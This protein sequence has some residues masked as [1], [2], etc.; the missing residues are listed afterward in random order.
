MTTSRFPSFRRTAS[1]AVA[2]LLAAALAGCET[3]PSKASDASAAASQASAESVKAEAPSA[4]RFGDGTYGFM[5]SKVPVVKGAKPISMTTLDAF[6]GEGVYYF[7]DREESNFRIGEKTG[8]NSYTVKE[9]YPEGQ[10][11]HGFAWGTNVESIVRSGVSVSADFPRTLTTEADGSVKLYSDSSATPVTLRVK[12]YAFDVSGQHVFH[13]LRTR[14]NYPTQTAGTTNAV[15]PKG[16]VAYMPQI[17]AVQD[18]YV[19]LKPNAFTGAGSVEGFARNFSGSIPYCLS[20]LPREGFK[21]YG[22]TFDGAQSGAAAN[23]KTTYKY[24]TKTRYVKNKKGKKVKQTYKVKVPVTTTASSA[25]PGNTGKVSLLPVKTGTVFC[26]STS[27][28][29]VANGNYTIRTV[30]G[31]KGL[32]V[33]F[34]VDVKAPDTGI[35]ELSRNALS[36]ALVEMKRGKTTSVVPG[37]YL[38]ANLPITDFQYRFNAT[39]A[40]AV[41][42]ALSETAA[43]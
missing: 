26:Q 40:K 36:I 32:A 2:V 13:Y 1:A 41:R 28:T 35:F 37:Y 15:F 29:P 42:Q 9:T 16:S 4:D 17:S 24:V 34:P 8:D 19:V 12:L 22:I 6:K 5:L 23:A 25:A 33:E 31:T 38:K 27:K 11:A 10:K 43:K 20:Y 39:A 30:D 3:S 7:N 21:A 14:N 18:E